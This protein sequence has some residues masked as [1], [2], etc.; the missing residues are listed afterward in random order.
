[1]NSEVGKQLKD[2]SSA[3]LDMN[4]FLQTLLIVQLGLAGVPQ[5]NIRA[6]VGCDL[7]RVSKI[8]K[9]VKPRE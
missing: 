4:E 3:I 7:N 2:I 5:R 6:I 8:L 1:M 9:Q